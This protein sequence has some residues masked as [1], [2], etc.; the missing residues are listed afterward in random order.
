MAKLYTDK[1]TLKEIKSVHKCL[2]SYSNN[3]LEELIAKYDCFYFL[4]R[5]FKQSLDKN[6]LEFTSS[7]LPISDFKAGLNFL[8]NFSKSDSCMKS[9][10][11]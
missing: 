7:K 6:L 2:Y 10:A 3:A 4:I 8:E 5:N 1:Q 11:Y 9:E